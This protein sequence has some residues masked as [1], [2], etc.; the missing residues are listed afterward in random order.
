MTAEEHLE[1][2]DF[3][4]A[5]VLIATLSLRAPISCIA[6]VSRTSPALR[7][8]H[9]TRPS[10]E[11]QLTFLKVITDMVNVFRAQLGGS[12]LAVIHLDLDSVSAYSGEAFKVIQEDLEGVR[13][14]LIVTVCAD[15]MF[16]STEVANAALAW[17]VERGH[18]IMPLL[19]SGKANKDSGLANKIKTLTQQPDNSL[20]NLI[21]SQLPEDPLSLESD[22]GPVISIYK[23]AYQQLKPLICAY[24]SSVRHHAEFTEM[25][26]SGLLLVPIVLNF[27]DGPFFE[28][29]IQVVADV[30]LFVEGYV[31]SA[32]PMARFKREI[33]EHL[34]RFRSLTNASALAIE[35]YLQATYP[36]TQINVAYCKKSK[37]GSFDCDCFHSFV[38]SS[39]TASHSL[40]CLCPCDF[41]KRQRTLKCPNQCSSKTHCQCSLLCPCLCVH[42]HA[43][44][45]RPRPRPQENKLCS[46]CR[47]ATCIKTR[48]R[49]K[50]CYL[51]TRPSET[52]FRA[53]ATPRCSAFAPLGEHGL[54]CGSC[55]WQRKR[56]KNAEEEVSQ[57][58]KFIPTKTIA[59]YHKPIPI[60]SVL[61]QRR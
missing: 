9:G 49:C 58:K 3:R 7:N 13:N 4:G 8:S 16:R 14:A 18:L 39:S 32:S 1:Q 19:W 35:D 37:S 34:E 24:E 53:C 5:A 41:C 31:A 57:T 2:K 54:Y 38:F 23:H 20:E 56:Q 26:I 44:P 61:F 21:L 10:I 42:C 33:P 59:R 25:E 6:L 55:R 48:T 46:L 60:G 47:V 40:A 15:R 12:H 36:N 51:A 50:A 52:R 30:Q 29:C 28:E 17:A 22:V 45:Y 43:T 27:Q 11:R